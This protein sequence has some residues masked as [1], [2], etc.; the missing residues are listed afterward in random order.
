[1]T[2]D[3]TKDSACRDIKKMSLLV[4]VREGERKEIKKSGLN[5]GCVTRSYKFENWDVMTNARSD[6]SI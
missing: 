5:N 3:G 1:M 2:H 4:D 6:G